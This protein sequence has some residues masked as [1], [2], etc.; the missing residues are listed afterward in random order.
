MTKNKN[1]K[2]MIRVGKARPTRYKQDRLN[3]TLLKQLI[4]AIVIFGCV[5]AWGEKPKEPH[6]GYLY[7]AGGQ[8]GTKVR[9]TIGGQ[10]LRGV[11]DV[12]V[13]GDGVSAS[14][15]EFQGRLKTLNQDQ[16]QELQK[17]LNELRQKKTGAPAGKGPAVARKN[18]EPQ[19]KDPNAPAEMETKPVELPD[20][21]L[22][23]NLDKLSLEGLDKVAQEFIRPNLNQQNMQIAETVLI[24]VTIAPD[25]APGDREVRLGCAAGLSNLMRF[26]VGT[27][28]EMREPEF[29][30]PGKPVTTRVD[31]PAVI[32]GQIL[33]GE[34]DRYRFH[35]VQ[36]QSFV[37]ETQARRLIPYLSDAVPGWFQATLKLVDASGKEAAFVDDFR[38]DPD[39]VMYYE[40]PRNGD[41]VLEINDAI[42]RGRED[43]VYRVSVSQQP[44]ITRIFPLGAKAAT[45]TSVSVGGWNIT[46]QQ[47]KLDTHCGVGIHRTVLEQDGKRSN[48]VV[49]A[50]DNMPECVETEGNNTAAESQKIVLPL[51]IN[52]RIGS[53]DDTDIFG[54]EGR[55][56]QD[57]VITVFA[58]RLN[59]PLDSLIQLTD[60]AGKVLFWNDDCEDKESGLVTHYADSFLLARLPGD[61]TY[62]V[63]LADSQHH[64]GDEYGYRLHIRPPQPDFSIYVSP[65]SLNVPVGR[66]VP[67]SVHVFRKEGFEGEIK[68]ALK[69]APAGFI[70]DGDRVGPGRNT[71][72]MT[73]TTPLELPKRPFVIGFEGQ[74]LI[75]GQTVKRPAVV[76][77]DMMQAFIYRHLVA[78]GDIM[79]AGGGKW[80]TAA[81]VKL[82]DSTPVRISAGGSTKIHV[83]I[84]P[85]LRQQKAQ[86]ALS[87]APEGI[88]IEDM[89]M[90]SSGMTFLL[91]TDGQKVK[92]G[93]L[94]NLIIEI[95][96]QIPPKAQG[97]DTAKK[98]E[99]WN[100][101]GFLPA[102]P[103]EITK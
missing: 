18:K 59:S 10:L 93:F 33:P 76:C 80:R 6:I 1:S 39:P 52:G 25:A 19:K 78:S 11:N 26:W 48:S 96:A 103:V 71:I 101:F 44:F 49:Y 29:N 70:V 50:V 91:K 53:P 8:Q 86:L 2:Q 83:Q 4:M 24:E 72:R 100:H 84:P 88:S 47:L 30:D 66:I 69:D 51:I 85:I 75:H 5:T 89:Q 65:S 67:I 32:N 92:T 55:K 23:R 94:D 12:Y 79:V 22:L 87:E 60:K 61:G 27:L 43:F 54:F 35:G 42:Y 58:R 82:S 74:A 15:I 57:V 102:I 31:V 56:D 14:V 46:E 81:A 98:P 38:F 64:G 17:R 90:D 63:N 97:T 62:Y 3:M 99:Q 13:S 77:E 68:L 45:E 34:V 37:I 16:R 73:L 20:H 36:G 40:I 21:P 95:S 7:P 28:P 9:I 41:Y